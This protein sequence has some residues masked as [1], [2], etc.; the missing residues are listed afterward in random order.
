M[1]FAGKRPPLIQLSP[2]ASELQPFVVVD[3]S[4][5]QAPS[6]FNNPNIVDITCVFNFDHILGKRDH[7]LDHVKVN[8]LELHVPFFR[9]PRSPVTV[10]AARAASSVSADGP[11]QAEDTAYGVAGTREDFEQRMPGKVSRNCRISP[12]ANDL[13]IEWTKVYHCTIP[14]FRHL[15]GRRNGG[16]G[17]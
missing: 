4:V 11:P 3:K 1:F 9:D 13:N 10:T 8:G 14:M 5:L 15:Y 12:L 6:W 16:A 2:L 17:P 7:P